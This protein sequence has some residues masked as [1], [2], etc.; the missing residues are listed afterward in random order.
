MDFEHS[1]YLTD[2]SPLATFVLDITK[3]EFT[4]FNLAFIK[5]LKL[6]KVKEKLL[7]EDVIDKI[8]EEDRK[9]L[10]K[11]YHKLTRGIN[12]TKVDI[13]YRINDKT[14]LSLR[15][16][17]FIINSTSQIA[18]TVMDLTEDAR[19][20][21]TKEKYANKK[22]SVLNVLAHDLT[23]PLSVANTL[24]QSLKSKLDTNLGSQV[25]SI[26]K[27]ILQS[28]GLIRDL[29]NREFLETVEISLVKNR[30]NVTQKLQ[31][32]FEEYQAS[33]PVTKREF[34]LTYSSPEIFIELDEAKF[35]QILNNLM[36]NALKFTRDGGVISFDITEKEDS[37][38]FVFKDNGVGIPEKLQPVLFEKFTT[39]GR[40]GLQGESSTGLGMWVIK[41][42]VE[43]HNGKIWFESKENEG[44]AFY[45][46][47]PKL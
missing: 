38:L 7:V 35:I 3:R 17:P 44:S 25:E 1:T 40:K 30:V 15:L 19:S 5:L 42:I 29:V 10:K 31:E 9:Y 4:Y 13:R 24:S 26:S 20:L 45:F 12:N 14:F 41:T 16:A 34:I 2:N 23:G 43:W 18:S 37:V 22:N 39:A 28:L 6:K 8:S 33:S 11:T 32:Y 27:I 21:M 36:T 46:E 47:I